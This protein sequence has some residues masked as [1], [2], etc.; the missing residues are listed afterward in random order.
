ML[1]I[2]VC[3][4]FRATSSIYLNSLVISG[5]AII[6]TLYMVRVIMQDKVESVTSL[7]IVSTIPPRNTTNN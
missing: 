3:P 5:I 7:N 1:I 2:G 4:W 6:V